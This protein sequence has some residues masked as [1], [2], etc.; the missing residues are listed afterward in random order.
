M[1]KKKGIWLKKYTFF[2][3]L[4]HSF[5]INIYFNYQIKTFFPYNEY[6]YLN[7]KLNI[8]IFIMFMHP[9]NGQD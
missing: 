2:Q 6:L 4:N 5:F 9:A 8:Y 3:K 7:I 1:N